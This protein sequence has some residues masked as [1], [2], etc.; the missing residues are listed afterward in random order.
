MNTEKQ[1]AIYAKKILTSMHD[2]WHEVIGLTLSSIVWCFIISVCLLCITRFLV[3]ILLVGVGLTLCLCGYLWYLYFQAKIISEESISSQ[4]SLSKRKPA[5]NS[6]LKFLQ[7]RSNSRS[8]LASPVNAFAVD[9]SSMNVYTYDTNNALQDKAF[10]PPPNLMLNLFFAIIVTVL[11]LIFILI[12]I[13]FRKHM[14]IVIKL[15]DEACYAIYCIPCVLLQPV[16]T[17]IFLTILTFYFFTIGAYIYTIETPVVD[18][19]MFVE[20][21]QENSSSP[22]ALLFAHFSGSFVVWQFVTACEEIIVAGAVA[23]WYYRRERI[24]DCCPN[25]R[26][27]ICPTL[28]PI[29]YL[30]RYNLGTAATGSLLIAITAG[31]R[32]LNDSTQDDSPNILNR[33]LQNGIIL[34]RSCVNCCCGCLTEI[35]KYITHNAYIIAGMTGLG[36]IASGKRAASLLIVS[37]I[38]A[39]LLNIVSAFLLFLAKF[40]VMVIAG[41][42]SYFYFKHTLDESLGLADYWFPVFIIAVLSYVLASSFFSSFGLVLDTVFLCYCDD[43]DRN[44]GVSL[45]GSD[46]LKANMDEVKTKNPNQPNNVANYP[47]YPYENTASY[48]TG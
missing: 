32:L 10:D 42:I 26:I 23:N 13:F 31:L 34:A 15:F 11:C 8:A 4:L 20:F 35:I 1:L 46:R 41:V 21:V 17:L 18:E 12:I 22:F 38:T 29:I 24:G 48:P 16:P 5:D 36:F 45:Y 9:L 2:H 25:S 40:L 14:K 47:Y 44:K 19:R 37:A 43:L 30:V 28:G 27:G 3:V 6:V 33:S 39:W 7:E